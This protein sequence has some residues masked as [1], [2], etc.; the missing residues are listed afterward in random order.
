VDLDTALSVV[1]VTGVTLF[2]TYL[3]RS[4]A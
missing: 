3:W 2:I 1:T 4:V